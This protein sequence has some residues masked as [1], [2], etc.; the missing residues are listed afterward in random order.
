MNK[1]EMQRKQLCNNN[2]ARRWTCF[3]CFYHHGTILLNALCEL[4]VNFFEL[5]TYK[6]TAALVQDKEAHHLND[7]YTYSLII[8]KVT[9]EHVASV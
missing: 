1:V 2:I 6:Y 4:C 5:H 3:W 9:L 7:D 8:E